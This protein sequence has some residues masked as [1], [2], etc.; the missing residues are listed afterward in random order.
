MH[1]TTVLFSNAEVFAIE[2]VKQLFLIKVKFAGHS[3][4]LIDS[5][6]YVT[7]KISPKTP[8]MEQI[9]APQRKSTLTKCTTSAI[10]TSII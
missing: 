8:K 4:F 10:T 1:F 6:S 9:E 7:V 3:L 2:C 5:G